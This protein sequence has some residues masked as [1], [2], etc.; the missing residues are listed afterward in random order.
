VADGV[1]LDLKYQPRDVA[2]RLNSQKAIDAWF[3]QK[4][5]GNLPAPRGAP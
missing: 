2:Q 1:I 4:T 3:E 5:K